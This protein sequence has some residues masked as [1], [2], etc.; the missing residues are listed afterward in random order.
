MNKHILFN[1]FRANQINY[2]Q[3]HKN[4]QSRSKTIQKEKT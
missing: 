2:L 1:F 4:R 3:I